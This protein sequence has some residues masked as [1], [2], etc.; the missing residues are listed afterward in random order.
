MSQTCQH[1]VMDKVTKT[2]R[3]CKKYALPNSVFCSIHRT[4][5][6]PQ[7]VRQAPQPVRQAPQPVRQAPQPVRQAPQ[8][9]RQ[10]PQPVRQ[11]PQPVRQAPQPVRQAPQPHLPPSPKQLSIISVNVQS[12]DTSDCRELFTL[13]NRSG[14]DVICLQEDL[15]NSTRSIKGL[16]NYVMQSTCIAEP[17]YNSYLVNRIFVHQK[18]ISTVTDIREIDITCNCT[19]P[20][21]ANHVRV[22]G[23]SIVNLHMC[24]GRYD[25]PS[26][27]YL[28]DVRQKEIETIGQ[29]ADLIVGDF[30]SESTENDA[31]E[32]LSGYPLYKGLKANQRAEFLKYYTSH[33]QTLHDYGYRSAYSKREIGKTSI[34]G[35]T[36]DWMYYQPAHLKPL[37]FQNIPLL[38]Y[39]DHNG[40]RVDFEVL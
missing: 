29:R 16:S 13:I 33:H 10:A 36:P 15:E 20:R 21:C 2:Q 6:A 4:Q 3:Q 40:V 32:S 17:L 23:I 38:K 24:G 30:N 39:T 9:V 26:Y 37:S 11:A 18:L 34:Y 19:V 28:F 5:Q 31:V 12:Y 25:D 14:V 8:P 7:P 1:L 27:R 22:K 35:G